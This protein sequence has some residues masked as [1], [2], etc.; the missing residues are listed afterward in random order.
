MRN[1]FS[2]TLIFLLLIDSSQRIFDSEIP[3]SFCMIA[4]TQILTPDGHKNIESLKKEDIILTLNEQT[5]RLD[6]TKILGTQTNLK[7]VVYQLNFEGTKI[8]V[9]DDHPFYYK[10]QLFSLNATSLYGTPTQTLKI[11]QKILFIENNRWVE[12]KLTSITKEK[13]KQ[14]TYTITKVSQNRLYFANSACVL[15]EKIPTT[16]AQIHKKY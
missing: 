15:V 14:T 10:G 12:K 3:T 4:G 13:K 8:T 16:Y 7:Q 6:K 11:G 2:L 9:T 1:L 5:N